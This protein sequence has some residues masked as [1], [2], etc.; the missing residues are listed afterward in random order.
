MRAK[1]FASVVLVWVLVIQSLS[2]RAAEAKSFASSR[3][4]TA[5]SRQSDASRAAW[6]RRVGA[7]AFDDFRPATAGVHSKQDRRAKRQ[8]WF[9]PRNDAYA[10]ALRFRRLELTI[11]GPHPSVLAEGHARSTP[12]EIS[13]AADA[14]IKIKQ[15]GLNSRLT[16]FKVGMLTPEVGVRL[17]CL[18]R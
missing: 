2:A 4:Q 18:S 10:L 3:L 12:I 14:A 17:T 15:V 9:A 7:P 6:R 11:C 1:R 13:K 16:T 8:H 5:L